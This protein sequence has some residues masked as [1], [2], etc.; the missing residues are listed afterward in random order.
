VTTP[1]GIGKGNNSGGRNDPPGGR[2]K[3]SIHKKARE[4]IAE[5]ERT[6]K[7]LPVDY[8]LGVMRDPAAAPRDRISAAAIAAPYCHPRLTVMQ[9]FSNP[10][11]L[12]DAALLVQ[13]R[14]LE[15]HAAAMPDD[16]EDVTDRIDRTIDDIAGLSIDHQELLFRR[17]LAAGTAG[18][19]RLNDPHRPGAVPPHRAAAEHPDRAAPQLTRPTRSAPQPAADGAPDERRVLLYNPATDELELEPAE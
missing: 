15:A 13:T 7:Q 4:L 10:D 19:Q 3:G 5:A 2:P 9:T 14:H 12:D 11:H 17:L 18:L 16:P 8:L 1:R 6:G